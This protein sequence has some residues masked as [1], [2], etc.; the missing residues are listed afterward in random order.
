ML[1]MGNILLMTTIGPNVQHMYI[2]VF[3]LS[4][5]ELSQFTALE[6]LSPQL[7]VKASSEFRF[8]AIVLSAI[9]LASRRER[10][11]MFIFVPSTR[12]QIMLWKGI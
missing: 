7:S 2:S 5:M 10:K 1:L 4:S 6:T 11:L 8:G 12:G 3:P 9:A